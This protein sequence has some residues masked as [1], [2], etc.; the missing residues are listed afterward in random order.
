MACTFFSVAR[1][2]VSREP[3]RH[4]GHRRLIEQNCGDVQAAALEGTVRELSS[5]PMKVTLPAAPDPFFP[6][7]T[8]TLCRREGLLAHLAMDQ[9]MRE[10][11]V[12]F[13]AHDLVVRAAAA[14][15]EIRCALGHRFTPP[16]SS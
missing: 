5:Y 4:R 3:F 15:G 9:S 8:L 14:A 11:R 6:M 10:V 2:S 12:C 1:R 16:R 7:P 13:Y